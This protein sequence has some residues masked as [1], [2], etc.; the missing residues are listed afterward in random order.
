MTQSNQAQTPPI[1]K[2][3]HHTIWQDGQQPEPCIV[4]I[5]GATGDLTQRKLLPTL[6]HLWHD[7]PL[8]ESFLVVAFARR[9]LNDEQ[10]RTMV[11]DSVNTFMPEDDRLDSTAQQAFAQRTF[12][13]QSNFNDRAGYEKLSNLLDSLDERYDTKGNRIFYMATPPDTDSEIIYHLGGS[14]LARPAHTNGDEASWTRIIIEKPFGHD[15]PSAQKL[16]RE[17]ARVFHEN[18]IFRID[19]YMG[20]E[21]VQN[22]LALR[23]ANGIFEPLWN[24]KYIDHV[25]VIVAESLGIGT[26]AEFYEGA[27]AIRDIVQNHIMQVLCLTA[28]EPPVA[29]DA[30]AIRDEKVKVLRAVP[31]LTPEEV[32]ERTVRGQYT[33]GT[34]DGQQVIG[35]KEE[36]NV[37]PDS[38]T[39]T[40]VAIK[41]F[42]ENWRWAG[43]PF[44]IRTGKHLPA[45]STEVTVQFK[46]VP[47][48][49]YKPNE[50]TGLQPNRL[51]LRIQPNEGI[52]LKFGAKVPGAARH[53]SSV[54]MNFSYVTA[55]GIESP[56]AYERLLADC[57]VGDSTLFIRRDEIEMAWRIIDSI[58]GAWKN[59]P[60]DT[61]HP[62]RAG[63]WGPEEADTLIK[64]DGRE[65][66]N[67]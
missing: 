44:Y 58:T 7:H 17:V 65:W 33:A 60:A 8:P 43:V 20:K 14:G 48:Q 47:H 10:W 64:K 61:V 27:G 67:P 57:M 51:T 55:F 19:H 52:S 41:L 36:K 54:D 26:R 40:Y 24:Q 42:I 3:A 15:L 6:A 66:D 16:N 30:D 50:T 29:F 13:C 59:M 25:Q 46:R 63:S 31:A 1:R 35:Y 34:V 56:D 38:T 23:F 11:V 39:E 28:M 53:L 45:R 62:Y 4:V 22:I 49:L 32:A 2:L 21:T 37:N 18:Q 5:F 12:Y 9:P